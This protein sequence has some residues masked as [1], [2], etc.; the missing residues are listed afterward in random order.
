MRSPV[1]VLLVLLPLVHSACYVDPKPPGSMK[2][3]QDGLD[4][5][6]HPLGSSWTNSKC[7]HCSCGLEG[8][9]CCDGLPSS[10]KAPSDCVVEYDY[11][12]CTY[13]VVKKSDRSTDCPHFPL[14]NDDVLEIQNMTFQ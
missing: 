5:T 3:C 12:K 13:Q 7:V 10:I 6:W 4:N 1:V 9:S 2:M 8:T 11:N 14:G